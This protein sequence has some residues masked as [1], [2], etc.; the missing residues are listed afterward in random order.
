MRASEFM[1]NGGTFA[2]IPNVEFPTL[3]TCESSAGE[4]AIS[5]KRFMNSNLHGYLDH[6]AIAAP[7][8]LRLPGGCRAAAF[9]RARAKEMQALIRTHEAVVREFF[10]TWHMTYLDQEGILRMVVKVARRL[11]RH[12]RSK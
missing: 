9:A 8:L 12:P 11:P 4:S 7:Q 1:A 5:A 2:D 10:S 3:P 6:M